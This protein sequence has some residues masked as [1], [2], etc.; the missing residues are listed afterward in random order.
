MSSEENGEEISKLK[1]E[2]KEK[3]EALELR[4]QEAA[5]AQRQA[6]AD[7]KDLQEKKKARRVCLQA[8]AYRAKNMLF[9]VDFSAV[10]E[11]LQ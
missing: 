7:A 1:E 8:D 5:A 6:A 9:V 10:S 11:F 3:E 2:I 4:K